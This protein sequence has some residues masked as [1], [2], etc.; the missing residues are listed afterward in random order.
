ME[1]GFSL[2]Q[3]LRTLFKKRTGYINA[4]NIGFGVPL[5]IDSHEEE[6]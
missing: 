2:K 3:S 6:L 4:L 1:Y 5:A